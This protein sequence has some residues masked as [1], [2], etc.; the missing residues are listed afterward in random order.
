M[1]QVTELSD[2]FL[3]L[4]QDV[5]RTYS[6]GYF[7]P[8]ELS[9]QAA[10]VAKIDLN[11]GKLGLRPGMTLLDV[12]CGWGATMRRA[13]EK[14]DVDVIGLTLSEEQCAYSRQLLDS[15]GTE[16]SGRVL[17]Q[18]WEG[19]DEP[20]DR[21]VCI[22][23]LERLSARRYL[24]FFA[25]CFAILPAGGRMTIQS[26]TGSRRYDL[27]ARGTNGRFVAFM[28]AEIFPGGHIPTAQMM[29]DHGERA[30]FVV[31]ECLSL[32]PHYLKTLTMWADMLEANE[33][34]ALAL[35]SAEVYH[36]Y[37]DYLRSCR[38]C[39]AGLGLDVNL[40]SYRKP[41]GSH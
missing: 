30:G 8:P 5:S 36:R 6:C 14:Y 26:N 11:L 28:L 3:A 27:N 39:V 22:E 4:F 24:D 15:L 2:E 23:A 18:R 19:F 21:I 7:D 16:H 41:G 13:I 40:V 35:T 29:A 17:L 10:E 34:Q 31:E 25:R 37:L 32:L 20:V 1:H 38:H 9:L 33:D 12:G